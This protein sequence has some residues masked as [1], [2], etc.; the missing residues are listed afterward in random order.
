MSDL[1]TLTQVGS[2]QEYQNEELIDAT[3][4]NDNEELIRSGL[5]VVIAALNDGTVVQ[6]GNTFTFTAS[7]NFNGGIKTNAIAP[8]VAGQNTIYDN[9]SGSDLYRGSETSANKYQVSSEVD[10]KIS[11]AGSL[12]LTQTYR[13]IQTGDF[14][15]VAPG[16]YGIDAS[17][18]A[19]TV[20]LEASPTHGTALTFFVVGDSVTEVNT[21]T[22]AGNGN[23]IDGDG[24]DQILTDFVNVTLYYDSASGWYSV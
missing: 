19:I 20:T 10:S 4:Q 18:G 15:A 9:T 12:T 14:N 7:Q 17:G 11:G 13:G 2:R 8:L 5:N 24:D 21:F 1:T 3:E 6:T 22:I 16:V 23:N